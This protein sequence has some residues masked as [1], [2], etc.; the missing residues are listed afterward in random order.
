VVDHAWKAEFQK[1]CDVA[2]AY[3]LDL[4]QIY[5]DQDPSFFITNDIMLCIARRFINDIKDRMKQHKLI[6]IM[7]AS[8]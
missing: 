6:D 5:K 8:S 2:M 3:G 4:K 1:A 7:D